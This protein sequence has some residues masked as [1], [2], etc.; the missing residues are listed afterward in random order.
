MIA[1]EAAKKSTSKIAN[2]V[3]SMATSVATRAKLGK[4]LGPWRCVRCA[5]LLALPWSLSW[6]FCGPP[7]FGTSRSIGRAAT[8]SGTSSFHSRSPEME[9][10]EAQKLLE[11]ILGVV[12]SAGLEA[13]AVRGLQALR[14]TVLTAVEAARDGELQ[15]ALQ[16]IQRLGTERV[17]DAPLARLLRRLF[18]KLG[19]TYVKLGQFIASSPTLFPAAYVREFQQCLDRTEPTNFQRIKRIVEADLG[20]PLSEVYESFDE[21]PLASASVAQVHSAVLKTGERVAVKVQK[22]GVDRVLKADL[23]FLFIAARTLEFLSPELARSSLVDIVSEIRSSMLDELDFTKELDNVETFRRFLRQ[24]GLE[25]I[26]AAPRTFPEAS[27]KKVLTMELFSGVPL[28][29]LEGISRNSKNP[30]QTLINALNVWSL[31]VR[32]CEIFHADV[33]A[34]NLLVLEDGRVGFIDFGIV[35]RIPPEIWSAVEGL[36]VS[37]A[38]NDARGMARNLIAMGA[39]E[40][41]VDEA[42]LA[43]DVA[44]VLGRI[45]GLEPEVVLR[46][47]GDGRVVAEVALDNDQVTELLLEVVRVAE[48]NGLKLPREFALLVKQALYFDRYTKLLAPDL[49]PLRD[50]RVAVGEYTSGCHI[51]AMYAPISA[52]A[53]S[54]MRDATYATEWDLEVQSL[55]NAVT[56]KLRTSMTTQELRSQ[57]AEKLG[58]AAKNQLW[59]DSQTLEALEGVTQMT[60]LHAGEPLKPLPKRFDI[61]L[62]SVRE[63]F[64]TG[65]SSAFTIQYRLRADAEKG[66]M[67]LEPWRKNDHDTLLYNMREKKLKHLKS[68]W[69]AGTQETNEAEKIREALPAFCQTCELNTSSRLLDHVQ[70]DLKFRIYSKSVDSA[71]LL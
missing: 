17:D 5:V 66:E 59:H 51:G 18:Q 41:T 43:Q 70:P 22:P 62:T 16:T 54:G 8:A 67:V 7:T 44:S 60:V 46:G 14:A 11:D 26:A 47:K 35:G 64:R 61:R 32:G 36:V 65:Y 31:S 1:K 48:S 13:G 10:Q 12:R 58:I 49:D 20:R 42:S 24:N 25:R 56:L 53:A 4:G 28:T 33:H 9:R 40:A 52:P 57:I 50:E 30:E 23:G 34:G 2:M 27:S 63:R 3:T 71:G 15:E 39:T 68:H 45:A 69:M 21:E 37:F 55:A 29:D 38:A 19:S 6:T